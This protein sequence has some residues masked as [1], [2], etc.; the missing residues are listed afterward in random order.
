M[1]GRLKVVVT[2]LCLFTVFFG[3]TPGAFGQAAN[4]EE[5]IWPNPGAIKLSKTAEPTGKSGE[6]EI[7]LKIEGKN[8]KSRSDVVLVIDKSGSMTKSPNQSRLP[9]AKEAAKKFVDNLLIPGSETRIAVVSFSDSAST[10]SDF[11]GVNQKASL[12]TAIERIT[13]S[14]GTNIQAGLY[15]A[16]TLLDGSSAQNKVI[17]LLS[18]G[19][20]TYSYKAI[21]AESQSWPGNKYNF[22]LTN[23]GT[24]NTILGDGSNYNL[25]KSGCFL[26]YCWGETYKVNGHEVLDNGIATLSEAKLAQK[27]G[28]GIYSIG[29]DV[30]SGNNA[31]YVLNNSQNKGYYSASS[32]DLDKIYSELAGKISY[33]AQN[34][35]ITDPM[36]EMFNLV[37]PAGSYTPSQGTISWDPVS[38]T[39]T[40]E[41]GNIMEGQPAT[42]TYKVVMDQT[43]N[44]ESNKLYPTNGTT[45]MNYTDVNGRDTSKNFEVPR[46]SIGSGS[47]LIKGYKVNA[48]GEPVNAD[49][50]V[51]E[52]REFAE[53]LHSEY[54]KDSNGNEALERGVPYTVTAPILSGYQLK[55]GTSPQD[56]TLTTT[57]LTPTIWF[58]YTEAVEQTVTVKYLEQ[59]SN[60]VLAEATT[61]NGVAGQTIE[62]TAEEVPGYTPTKLKDSYT[63][64][65]AEGQEY[66]FHYTANEQKVTVRYVDEDGQDLIDPTTHDGKT[67][68]TIEL[69]AEEVPGYTPTKSKD[70][71]TFTADENQVYTF[72]YTAG[73]Q[74]VTVRYVDEAGRDLI[75]PTTHKGKTGQTIELTAEE[76]PGYTPTKLKD[77]YTFTAAEGQE[78]IFHYTANE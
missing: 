53:Q 76:V 58:G 7:T 28:I 40:W 5:V 16:R 44:P 13:A 67:G 17:V 10:V 70:S 62:L 77:S 26:G 45:T 64:T 52:G 15:K 59:G 37:P 75:D 9:K 31:E 51:V 60:K 20:P 6:W 68:Q 11:S 24:Y 12:K 32:A 29:L 61:V 3:L 14:G 36:G 34:A 1:K 8:I 65:A 39:F 73:D 43:K 35:I 57:N 22:A 33:A 78:Y 21:A 46:V 63:F 30:G 56:V 19:E 72:H 66:I 27:A 47:I 48:N 42:L 69:T 4:S 71:Y 25:E 38:E 18:D 49:G 2:W 41:A 50:E 74:T 23:F 54:F 55:V